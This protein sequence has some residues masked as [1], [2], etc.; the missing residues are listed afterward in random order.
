MLSIAAIASLSTS[1]SSLSSSLPVVVV[2]VLSPRKTRF[3]NPIATPA[4]EVTACSC[5]LSRRMINAFCLDAM[6]SS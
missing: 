3:K 4:E 6:R 5:D 1:C 2:V